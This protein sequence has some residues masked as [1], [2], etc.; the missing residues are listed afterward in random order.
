MMAALTAVQTAKKK[1]ALS[2]E[3]TVAWMAL[4]MV[5]KK[6]ARRAARSAELMVVH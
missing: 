3:T 1:V 2:D 4:T 6:V 5:A